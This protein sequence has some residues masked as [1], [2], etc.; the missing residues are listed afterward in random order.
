MSG[1]IESQPLLSEACQNYI[2]NRVT[3]SGV[4]ILDVLLPE[5]LPR[6][7]FVMVGGEAGTG[8]SALV[9]ELAYHTLHEKKEP[10]I[11][12][13]NENS[14]LSLYHRFLGLGWDIEP[15]IEAK[16]LRIVDSFTTM[17]EQTVFDK[18]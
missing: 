11:Y 5:G 15:F 1:L 7:S 10:V 17:I 18:D 4:S 8:K 16:S 9:S 6:N 2:K 14:P 13:V 3:K 12:V